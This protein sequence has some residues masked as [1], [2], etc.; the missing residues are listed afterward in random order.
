M[1]ENGGDI[2]LGTGRTELTDMIAPMYPSVEEL[3]A[4]CSDVDDDRPCVLC[5]YR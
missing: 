2:S 1:Y 4:L 3:V 5:E